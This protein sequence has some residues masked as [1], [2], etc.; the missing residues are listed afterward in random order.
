MRKLL[1]TLKIDMNG[2]FQD[3]RLI[4]KWGFDGAS[5]QSFYKQKFTDNIIDINKP[6]D[7]S[8]LQLALFP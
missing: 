3:M 2:E 7:E 8:V 1:N 6:R 5:G 4:S